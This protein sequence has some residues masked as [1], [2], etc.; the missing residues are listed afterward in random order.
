MTNAEM[1]E[2]SKIEEKWIEA[3]N[4]LV[5]PVSYHSTDDLGSQPIHANSDAI[6]CRKDQ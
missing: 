4:G 6:T 1:S 3:L 5:T 2:G